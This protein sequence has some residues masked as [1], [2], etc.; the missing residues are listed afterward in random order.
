MFLN[1]IFKSSQNGALTYRKLQ[2]F[3]LSWLVG[4]CVAFADIQALERD[5]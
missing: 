5:H 2:Y 1:T 4:I 3:F